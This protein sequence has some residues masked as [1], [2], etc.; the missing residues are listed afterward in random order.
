M[1]RLTTEA[2]SVSDA[3]E[4]RFSCRAFLDKPVP[5]D[6]IRYIVN[7]ALR[8]PS[9]GNLQPWH[10]WVVQGPELA[11]FIGEIKEKM[12]E[13]PGG[14]G[15]E[16]HIYPPDLADPYNTRRRDIG[17]RMYATIGV[18]REDKLGR[19]AQMARNFEFF[20]APCAM[21]FALDKT[22]QEGQWSDMGM[23]IQ[24]IML[25]ARERGL[26]SCPQEAW[27]IWAPS[28]K[29]FLDIP[30][31]MTFFC[32]LALGYADPDAPINTLETPRAP[33]DEMVRFVGFS[34]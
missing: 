28:V 7:K 24:S 6:D 30:D 22:M 31:T 14:E 11:G 20:G 5:E 10:A 32:G 29:K 8:A 16:Y 12:T 21:F 4:T 15:S 13:N 19:T 27:A 26:H 1:S 3:L 2:R 17:E 23:M 25:L 34:D 33:I 18:A 9:G